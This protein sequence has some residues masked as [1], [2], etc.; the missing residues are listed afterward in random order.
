M[1]EEQIEIINGKYVFKFISFLFFSFVIRVCIIVA[2]KIKN[3][4]HKIIPTL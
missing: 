4:N 1:T 2:F 3:C